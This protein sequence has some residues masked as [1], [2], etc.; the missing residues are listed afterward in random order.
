MVSNKEY[1]CAFLLCRCRVMKWKMGYWVTTDPTMEIFWWKGFHSRIWKIKC[2]VDAEILKKY[3]E[4]LKVTIF[5]FVNKSNLTQTTRRS[6]I[7]L[8]THILCTVR[9]AK[10]IWQASE[11]N[12]KFHVIWWLEYE[13]HKHNVIGLVLCILILSI[14]DASHHSIQIFE[15]SPKFVQS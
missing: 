6:E 5:T 15:W 11:A 13:C 1:S 2:T 10:G 7:S 8:H 14:R 3:S 4:M 9:R 12:S